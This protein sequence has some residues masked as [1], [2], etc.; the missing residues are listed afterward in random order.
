MSF[1]GTGLCS[2]QAQVGGAG[3]GIPHDDE[4]TP[5]QTKL[6]LTF[7]NSAGDNWDTNEDE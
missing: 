3:A 7:N 1:D 2:G 5:G 4:G 6:K